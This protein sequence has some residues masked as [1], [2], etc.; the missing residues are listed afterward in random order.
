MWNGITAR[1]G[2]ALRRIGI[3][4]RFFGL[5]G[6]L[7][8][9]EWVPFTTA[10]QE[11]DAG[12]FGS[13]WPLPSGHE[14]LYTI[15]NRKAQATTA[16]VLLES[17]N[18][19]MKYYDCYL[20]QQLHPAPAASGAPEVS[21]ELEPWGFG[22]IVATNN[23]SAV[24]AGL[25]SEVVGELRTS[26]FKQP[27]NL[28]A[29]LRTMAALTA[30]P[31]ASFST[32]WAYLKQT[33]T[34]S[35][36]V[37]A[38]PLLNATSDEVYVPGNPKFSFKA[39][40]V[41]IEGAAGSGVGVQFPFEKH[42]QR[43]HSQVLQ[44][45]AM[46]VDKYPVTNA[47]YHAYLEASGYRPEDTSN[48]LKQNFVSGEVRPGWEQRPVTYVSVQ[49]ARH[50]C[51]Y[52]RKRLPQAF[53]WQYFAQGTDG[54]V[55]PWGNA[56]DPSRTPVLQ[57]NHTNPGPDPI[58]LHPQGASTFGV[59]DLISSV[60]Q[61][62]ST[63]EDAHTASVVL[64]GGSNYAPR[65]DAHANKGN[66]YFRQTPRLDSFG[67][68]NMMSPSYD[69]AGTISFRC[70][71][72]AVEDTTV[73]SH[74]ASD[75]PSET[76]CNTQLCLKSTTNMCPAGVAMA[77]CT[78]DL[79]RAGVIDWAHFGSLNASLRGPPWME[80]LG[81]WH[82][83]KKASGLNQLVPRLRM[84]GCTTTPCDL[85]TTDLRT[86]PS[87]LGWPSDRAV[88]SWNNGAPTAVAPSTARA[89]VFSNVGKFE[90]VVPAPPAG[91]R[92]RVLT[93]Y[94]GLFNWRGDLPF[95]KQAL[96]RVSAPGEATISQNI[97]HLDGNNNDIK[98]MAATIVY[99]KEITVSYELPHPDLV[100]NIAVGTG[101]A[102]VWQHNLC[103]FVALQ[104]ATIEEYHDAK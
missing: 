34:V 32:E 7:T 103:S 68:L 82:I 65:R 48:W 101:S 10:V 30:K 49:D 87:Q 70:V 38:R 57:N 6:F 52:H 64:R 40:S 95:V 45:G 80:P 42:P 61:I 41:E 20:G 16:H 47:Q 102:T 66:W 14:T 18:E 100:C 59:H 35:P 12:V 83:V 22:C 97:T 31:L 24:G 58:G 76:E 8:S 19:T 74:G 62:T 9:L 39:S 44:I 75:P 4:L 86:W 84:P 81:E 67:V 71:A 85:N 55:Y 33:M 37:P 63:F 5:R 25:S 15:I 93:L 46:Y 11:M 90:L 26:H 69:R 51:A 56:D 43:S 96:L 1:D 88:F 73:S 23:G 21:V 53:E 92:P 98:N 91:H 17:R 60:W 94:L 99:T 2:E 29:L 3:L 36:S 78:T 104:A 72:D 79:S 13:E 89:G 27:E 54:R 77:S 28:S 50:Y